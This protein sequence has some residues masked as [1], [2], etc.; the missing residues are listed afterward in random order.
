MSLLLVIQD[1]HNTAPSCRHHDALYLED[2]KCSIV[3]LEAQDPHCINYTGHAE[4][5]HNFNCRDQCP[6]A[7]SSLGPALNSFSWSTFIIS[8]S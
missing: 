8:L 5:E 3:C 1:R 6:V 4:F 2:V 7:D